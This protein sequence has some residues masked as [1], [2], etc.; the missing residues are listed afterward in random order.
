MQALLCPC[1]LICW[2][3]HISE[4]GISQS[5]VTNR[6]EAKEDFINIFLF[7]TKTT[8]SKE[9]IFFE[10]LHGT[11]NPGDCGP[12]RLVMLDLHAHCLS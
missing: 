7:I 1:R 3:T 2:K 8:K 6:I 11:S 9:K 12:T 5:L 10:V 4:R